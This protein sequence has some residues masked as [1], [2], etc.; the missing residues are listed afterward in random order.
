MRTIFRGLIIVSRVPREDLGGLLKL[1]WH[2]RDYNAQ[3]QRLFSGA[4]GSPHNFHGPLAIP[5]GA[6][7]SPGQLEPPRVCTVSHK[8]NDEDRA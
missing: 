3:P 6:G 4:W 2:P 1:V 5:A 7:L 8:S